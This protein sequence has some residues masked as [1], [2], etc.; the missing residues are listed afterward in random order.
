[1]IISMYRTAME[2]PHGLEADHL[3]FL[4]FLDPSGSPRLSSRHLSD[5]SRLRF[6]GGRSMQC[7]QCQHE[8]PPGMK[9]C[10]ECA[11]PLAT[12]CPSC[13]AANPPEKTSTLP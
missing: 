11:A 12:T 1:M 6:L 9:F 2:A 8:N 7:P 13:G 10:G 4:T 5:R 3:G